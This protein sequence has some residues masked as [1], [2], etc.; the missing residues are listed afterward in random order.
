MEVDQV[1]KT[2]YNINDIQ[3]P[4]GKQLLK[5]YVCTSIPIW[6]TYILIV[7]PRKKKKKDIFGKQVRR[8]NFLNLI[9]INA[10]FLGLCCICNEHEIG[11]NI[12]R[13]VQFLYSMLQKCFP[14]YL[15]NIL[16]EQ[17]KSHFVRL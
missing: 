2:T 14:D 17:F 9:Y 5:D 3:T 12:S 10:Q 1:H 4:T 8:K 7:L 6:R 11:Y 16:G 15:I 13:H